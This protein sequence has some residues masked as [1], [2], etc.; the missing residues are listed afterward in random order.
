M[1]LHNYND[2]AQTEPLHVMQPYTNTS[3]LSSISY[4]T[5]RR[6]QSKLTDNVFYLFSETLRYFQCSCRLNLT[7]EW[8]LVHVSDS[9]TSYANVHPNH[10]LASPAQHIIYCFIQ[11]NK[12]YL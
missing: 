5:T 10:L 11:S 6:K 7:T 1:C 12:R 8:N 9:C 2:N 4:L 3:V